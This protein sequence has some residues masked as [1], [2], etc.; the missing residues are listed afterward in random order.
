MLGEYGRNRL[1]QTANVECPDSLLLCKRDFAVKDVDDFLENSDVI[2][3]SQGGERVTGATISV[4]RST[5]TRK[6]QTGNHKPAPTLLL[7][8]RDW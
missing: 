6:M 4:S 2:L 5:A 1:D 7:D 3:E 8:L